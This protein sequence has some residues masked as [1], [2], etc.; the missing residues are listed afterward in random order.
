MRGVPNKEVAEMPE[1]PQPFPGAKGEQRLLFSGARGIGT[2]RTDGSDCRALAVQ[3]P[4][5]TRWQCGP[6]YR[7]ETGRSLMLL[8]SHGDASIADLVRGAARRRVWVRDAES[9]RL[10]ELF[11]RSRPA[12]WM[13]VSAVFDAGRRAIVYAIIDGEQRLFTAD[14][15]TERCEPLTEPGSGFHY[16]ESLSPDA[17]RLACH[18]TYG[19]DA[20]VRS[21]SAH[22]PAPYS[23]N[24]IDLTTHRRTL[25]A[26][27]PGHLCF[28][29]VWSPDGRRLA[30]LDCESESDPAHFWADVCV[31]ESDGSACRRIT[32][33]QSHWF[34]TSH[35]TAAARGGGSNFVAWVPGGTAGLVAWTPRLPGSRPDVIYDPERADHEEF[36]FAPEHARGGTRL[37]LLDPDTAEARD[38]T[39]PEEGRW[40]FR[41]AF[42]RDGRRFAYCRTRPGQ[43][44]ELWVGEDGGAGGMRV[45]RGLDGQGAD[46]PVWLE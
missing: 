29:P 17:T 13:G 10:N 31:A 45:S 15:R 35:G 21:P 38:L 26:G 2:V 9:G 42:A 36:V 18:V 3:V 43:S 6:Q 27:Q 12:P 11:T 7:D 46:F 28:G 24:V 44:P 16:G 32:S 25:I 34:A 33:G 8:F 14:L 39:P 41:V 20:S 23:I 4:G 22:L 37:Q 30:F 1:S 5:E 40:D 19:K